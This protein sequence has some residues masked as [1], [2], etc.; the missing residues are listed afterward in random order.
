M[1]R[2]VTIIRLHSVGFSHRVGYDCTIMTT[3]SPRTWTITL[4]AILLL[5][6]WFVLPQFGVVIFTALM[7]FVFYP[8]FTRLRRKRG[9]AAAVITLL[10]SFL[11]VV[12][13]LSFITI[14]AIGQLA[15]FADTASQAQYW[16][17][18]PEFVQRAV[19]T[20]NDV[21]VP[22]TGKEPSITD[23]NVTDFLRTTLPTLARASVNFLLGLLS[24]L[25]QL[26]I[27]LLVY[28][29]LFIELLLYGPQL[30]KKIELLSP[31]EPA[32]TRQYL[33][34]IGLMANAMVTGQLIISM[35]ISAISA[36]LLSLL[37]YGHYFF[38]F[39]I[40]FTILNFIPLGCGIVLTPLAIYSMFTGQFWLGLLVIVLYYLSGNLDPVM[41]SR[42]IPNKIQLSVGLTMLSTFC[43]IAYFGILGVIYGPIIMIVILTTFDFYIDL[44]Q[45][46]Q[47]KTLQVT[48]KAVRS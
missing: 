30:L 18:M 27:A 31:F 16:E 43:G 47:P 14:A 21:L 26:G 1:R 3:T 35:I 39:F 40:L 41:R 2:T 20:A 15:S 4:I 42:L 19:D 34:R 33:E 29:F 13:P 22:I 44:K 5:L 8:L 6:F 28:I 11:V 23:R 32:V 7:A 25:P 37:G 38:I 9:G 45:T 12:I 36:G 46:K 24:S 17:R 48:G 10:A